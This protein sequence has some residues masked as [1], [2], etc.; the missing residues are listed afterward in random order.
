MKIR[1]VL[2]TFNGMS[3]GNVA[4]DKAGIEFDNYYSSE[5]DKKAIEITQYNYP[6]TIQLGDV[7]KWREWDI[8]WS[9]IDLLLAGS[10]CQGFSMAGK[11]LNFEDERSKLFF[12][13]VD[14]L[15]HIKKVNPNIKFLLENVIMPQNCRDIISQ[16][17]GEYYREI[18]SSLFTAQSRRR[19]YWCNWHIEEPSDKKVMFSDVIQWEK[20]RWFEILPWSMTVWGGK[21]K[22]DTLRTSHAEK[23]F[24]LTTNKT[25]C[26]NYYLNK[27]RTLMTKLTAAEAEILQGVPNGYTDCVAEGHAFKAL[28]NG[29]T[30]DV[31][32]HIFSTM[33]TKKEYDYIDCN[34]NQL[35]FDFCT[36]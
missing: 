25:H 15:N 18:N 8:N 16:L 36:R 29:W 20:N 21:R 2:S 14:I 35:E 30:V 10:P 3:C 27:D 7:T 33:K 34:A 28:G 6:K 11:K 22:L 32:A 24:T 13:F 17:T 12:V 31:I 26:R 23:S 19:L 4:L 1:N 9:T 5:V